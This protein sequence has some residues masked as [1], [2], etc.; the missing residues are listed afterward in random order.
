M[1]PIILVVLGLLLAL[2]GVICLLLI[3]FSP[4]VVKIR[5]IFGLL[6]LEE[7]KRTKVFRQ[8]HR[9]ELAS[10]SI[11]AALIG[12]ALAF[13]GW[14][15]GYAQKGED[16]WFYRKYKQHYISEENPGEWDKISDDGKYIDNN[17]NKYTYYIL[18]KGNDIRFCNDECR[19]IDDLREKL[20][21]IP[22]ENTVIIAD[23]Y[24]VASKYE[25]V[26]ALLKEMGLKYETE[27]V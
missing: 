11:I 4:V 3:G 13:I 2:G 17:G 15:M 16:F 5:S 9:R 25:A 23:S 21:L 12:L 1:I 6:E 7:D 10:Y 18:V 27:E 8:K 26:K 24:A 20:N 22:R 19:T 14:C